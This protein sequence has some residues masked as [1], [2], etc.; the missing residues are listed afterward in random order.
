MTRRFVTMLSV[1][2]AM[3]VMSAVA[4]G[5]SKP[6]RIKYVPPAGFAGHKWGDLKKN[7]DRLPAE[8]FRVGSA[9]APP[10]ITQHFDC[11]G[12]CGVTG[13]MLWMYET[14]Q[15]GGFYMLGE[16]AIDGQGFQFGDDD[17]VQFYPVIYQFCTNWWKKKDITAENFE[18][19][20]AL[21]GMRLLFQSETAEELRKLPAD[22]ITYYDRVLDKL[23]AR[24]GKPDSFVRRGVVVIAT[25]D[26]KFDDS[27][28]RKF[29]TYRW[30]P[31]FDRELRTPC[32]ASVTLT[33][34]P[35]TGVGTVFYSAPLVWEYAYAR[36]HMNRKGDPLFKVLHARR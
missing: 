27:P 26:S 20:S 9:W 2:L 11:P 24:F 36:Q 31:A 10:V 14:T 35:L 28:A 17:A 32:K 33:I 34:N 29:R 3:A 5:A 21:C 6:K 13:A 4:T 18:Q 7:F 30:C 16:Y 19:T 22:H 23:L 1:V 8:P 15:G 12:T 25:V